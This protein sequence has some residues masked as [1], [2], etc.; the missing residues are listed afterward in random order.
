MPPKTY[1]EAEDR[2]ESV[3][4]D[5]G[6]IIVLEEERRRRRPRGA[7]IDSVIRPD[8]K[9]GSNGGGAQNEPI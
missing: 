5:G 3:V 2:G 4:R 9:P 8:D 7:D 1:P 6:D